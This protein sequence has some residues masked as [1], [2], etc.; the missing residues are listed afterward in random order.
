[1]N[2]TI[3]LQEL[4]STLRKSLWRILALTIVAALISFA[5]STFLIKPTYQ[6]G[7]QILVTPK[8]Q[9]NDVIDASQVQS[10]VTLVNTYRV[11]IKSPAILEKV[12]AEVKN[13]PDSISALNNMITVESEQNSQVI[14][15]SVQNTDAAL[16][17]NVANSVAKVFSDDITDLMNVDNVKVLS[18]S[19]IPTTPVSPNILLNTAIAAVVGFLL[20]VGLAFLREVLDRRIR[21]EEQVHQILDLPVLGSIPDIE[22]KVFN[23]SKKASKREAVKQ[24]G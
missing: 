14:N 18:V 5:V 21:T 23:A 3:S 24:Y 22:S 4:F 12:Q 20:G 10:S 1:M 16:A 13:A 17:S 15:V 2:E 9:E 6:A 19:G 7:T 8:K 11:I